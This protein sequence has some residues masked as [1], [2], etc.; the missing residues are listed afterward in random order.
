MCIRIYIY[1]CIASRTIHLQFKNKI[2]T[3][4]S[5]LRRRRRRYS[6]YSYC[7]CVV[8]WVTHLLQNFYQ[9]ISYTHT[10]A[11]TQRAHTHTRTAHSLIKY[12]HLCKYRCCFYFRASATFKTISNQKCSTYRS[13]AMINVIDCRCLLKIPESSKILS[14][15]NKQIPWLILQRAYCISQC[16]AHVI[17][18]KKSK[19]HVF[20][21]VY[22]YVWLCVCLC[23]CVCTTGAW[24]LCKG[25]TWRSFPGTDWLLPWQQRREKGRSTLPPPSG[26]AAG[27]NI[28]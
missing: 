18:N 21:S 12:K 15:C 17:D 8:N 1:I 9:I 26:R 24:Q 5:S 3:T 13:R 23:I 11:H 7:F 14:K 4:R 16:G 27:E 28:A 10:H 19:Q 2:N 20:V 25:Q 6:C 22:M